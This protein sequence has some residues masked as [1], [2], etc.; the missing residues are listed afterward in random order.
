M[1]VPSR[2]VAPALRFTLTPRGPFSLARAAD[3]VA[4]FPPLAHQPRPA[5][6]GGA[7][8][9][10]FILDR[11]HRAVAVSLRAARQGD[12]IHVSVAGTENLDRIRAQVARIFSLDHDATE[13]AKL[14]ARDARLGALMDRFH[15]LRP[16]CFTS[17]YESACWAILSQRIAKA[18]AARIV[19]ELVRTHGEVVTLDDGAAVT[20]FPTPD[21]LLRVRVIPGV[22]ARKIPWLHD[23]AAAALDGRLDADALRALGDEGGPASLRA[24]PGIGEFWSSG[25]YL[26]ACGVADVFPS[27]PLSVAA[28]GELHGLGDAPPPSEVAAI[29]ERYRPFRMWVAFLLRVSAARARAASP[30]S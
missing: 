2:S 17:P 23:V 19:A 20:V 12:A 15:G 8:R 21:R 3:V 9:L 30:L 27:E 28:L 10:G 7:L 22:P 24:L 4:R 6:S 1:P 11:E 16:V 18:Q 14:G 5:P 29:V 26:R 25:I 13:Y